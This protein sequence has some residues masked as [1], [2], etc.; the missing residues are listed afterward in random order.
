M[1]TSIN[2]KF[3]SSFAR[4]TAKS[5]YYT[6]IPRKGGEYWRYISSAMNQP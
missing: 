4:S 3:P 1:L 5:G 6:T 2:F